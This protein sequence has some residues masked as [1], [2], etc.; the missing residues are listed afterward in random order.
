MAKAWASIGS[1]RIYPYLKAVHPSGERGGVHN[2]DFFF[3]FYYFL[4]SIIFYIPIPIPTPSPPPAPTTP[5]LS[6]T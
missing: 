2:Q 6:T 5:P 4:L 3:Y 1:Y